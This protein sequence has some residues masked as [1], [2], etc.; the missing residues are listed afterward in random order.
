M[1]YNIYMSYRNYVSNGQAIHY[2]GFSSSSS[3][4]YWRKNSY[5]CFSFLFTCLLPSLLSYSFV[6]AV[7][8]LLIK[9]YF[10]P[11]WC[12]PFLLF[13]YFFLFLYLLASCLQRLTSFLL[14][15]AYSFLAIV[16]VFIL[17]SFPLIGTFFLLCCPCYVC[18]CFC[19]PFENIRHE[20]RSEIY[21]I[22]Q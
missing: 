3:E 13:Y 8:F 7:V 4:D 20:H 9:S 16:S 10:F 1:E 21:S 14:L 6:H 17:L 15:S 12:A 5:K 22:V 2:Q 11:S 19:E 18:G